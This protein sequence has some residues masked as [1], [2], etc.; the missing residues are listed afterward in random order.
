MEGLFIGAVVHY[1][2]PRGEHRPAIVTK[3]WNVN[4]KA[5]LV[6]LQVFTD[7]AADGKEGVGGLYWAA[8]IEYSPIP[9][10][11]T[12]HFPEVA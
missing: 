4:G 3:I 5:G 12:W 1:V 8:T 7:G 9:K 6:N 11:Y 2:T 10:P